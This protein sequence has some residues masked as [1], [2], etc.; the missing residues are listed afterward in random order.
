MTSAVLFHNNLSFLLEIISLLESPTPRYVEPA[1][2]L[3][4]V[5]VLAKVQVPIPAQ[6]VQSH[7]KYV[8]P[9]KERVP[10][11][12]PQT[13]KMHRTVRRDAS[14]FQRSQHPTNRYVARS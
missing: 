11:H 5:P 13:W 2:V 10:R 9:V 12:M 6:K 8:N 1:L 7:K 3:A 14:H 4:S